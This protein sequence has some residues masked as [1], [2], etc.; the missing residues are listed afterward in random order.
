ML[1]K[2]ALTALVI[3]IVA[4]A[5]GYLDLAEGAT[6]IAHGLFAVAFLGFVALS[7]LAWFSGDGPF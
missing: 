4:G 2:W 5:I 1:L 7:A 6:A 3:S